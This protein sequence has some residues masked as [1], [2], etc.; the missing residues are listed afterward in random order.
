MKFCSDKCE[1][2]PCR[3]LKD[4]DKRYRTKYKMS[5]LENLEYIK[6]LGVGKFLESQKK[7]WT[8]KKCKSLLC[9][10]RDFCLSCGREYR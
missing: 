3:R 7:K 1:K 2:Y 10:H 8:C 4:L 9:V 5:M 6:K